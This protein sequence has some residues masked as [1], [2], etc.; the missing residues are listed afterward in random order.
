M[1]SALDLPAVR[2]YLKASD[3]F[4][5]LVRNGPTQTTGQ[6]LREL[7]GALADLYS[8][9]SR[10]PEIAPETSGLPQSNLPTD[11]NRELQASIA[12]LFGRFDPYRAIFDPT[13]PDDNEPVQYWLSL[14]LIEILEDQEY[15]RDLLEPARRIS[16]NDVVWQ[17]RFGFTSHWGR[18]ATVA[19]RVINS[20]LYHSSS[21]PWR[22]V[23][24]MP[25]SVCSWRRSCGTRGG[26]RFA[27]VHRA[28]LL[29]PSQLKPIR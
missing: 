20:L 18:H 15:A 10:L 22:D 8:A 24:R 7:D 27:R 21:N 4:S 2:S 23:R 16:P 5:A 6:F 28:I 3:R 17:W 25:N 13:D 14:D 1:T 26:A 12:Q 19:M 9:G 29:D 11:R